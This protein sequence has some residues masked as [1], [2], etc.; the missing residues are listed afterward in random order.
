MLTGQAPQQLAGIGVHEPVVPPREQPRSRQAWLE[1]AMQNALLVDA[2]QIKLAAAQEQIDAARGQRYPDIAVVGSVGR[3][4]Q[5]LPRGAAETWTIGV[6]LEM[7]LFAGGSIAAAVDEATFAAAQARLDLVEARRQ[8]RLDVNSA[9]RSVRAAAD[10]V[11]ALDQAVESAKAAVAAAQAGY[12][13]GNRTILDVIEA[14]TELAQRKAE[15]KQAWYDYALARL[16][17]RQAA[18]VL[19]YT[20]LA[21]INEQLSPPDADESTDMSN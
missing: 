12:R 2:A 6:Q 1:L 16:Q 8:L 10:R 7:P 9:W 19:D 5:L 15:R 13:L 18:G 21:R 17:L 20:A 4:E 14:E 3:T 11:A